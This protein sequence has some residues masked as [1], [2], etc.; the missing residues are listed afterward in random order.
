MK[1]LVVIG[2]DH[3]PIAAQ[4]RAINRGRPTW[5][6]TAY[7]EDEERASPGAAQGTPVVTL[8]HALDTLAPQS[9]VWFCLSV[10]SL[11]RTRELAQML[12]ERHAQIANLVHPAIDLEFVRI[13]HGCILPERTIVASNVV[14]GNHVTIG[15]NCMIN[16]DSV[17]EDFVALADDVAIG[18][19]VTLG[20]RT[21]VGRGAIVSI[22]V[23][24]GAGAVIRDAAV[25]VKD[26]AED[27]TV[28]GIPA[29][30]VGK[31]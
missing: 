5:R 17:V 28:A 16:H 10:R 24:V 4:V 6:L 9:D 21:Q 19:F 15:A 27:A 25:V 30:P 18:S 23:R 20:E 2:G 31:D 7:V 8:S 29:R 13:G 3:G 26:V 11:D 22:R 1:R 14:I 12:A